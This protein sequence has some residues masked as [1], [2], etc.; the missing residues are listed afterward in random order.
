MFFRFF[1][2]FFTERNNRICLNDN[3]NSNECRV[4]GTAVD[5]RNINNN[6]LKK[7]RKGTVFCQQIGKYARESESTTQGEIGL[8]LF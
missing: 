6:N 4:K 8:N 7:E 5:N 2:L 1:V 3:P